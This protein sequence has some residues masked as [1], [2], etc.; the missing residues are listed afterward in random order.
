MNKETYLE[1]LRKSL[2]VL[3]QAERDDTVE[4]YREYFDDAGI[5]NETAVIEELGSPKE[6]AKKI[7][8]D[9][10]DKKF[11]SEGQDNVE[12]TDLH[13]E[14]Q[15][16]KKKKENS[17]L[18]TFLIAVAA[19]LALPL[20]PVLF[21]LFIA[22][23]A[24]IFSLIIVF[25]S[26]IATGIGMLIAGIAV[27]AVSFFMLPIGIGKVLLMTGAGLVTLGIGI[28]FVIGFAKLL[29]LFCNGVAALFAKIVKNKRRE[30]K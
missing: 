29:S 16:N 10:V 2:K 27:V 6:L 24:V 14:G 25:I 21:A 28:C 7:L 9:V 3:P 26:F 17:A 5:E 11:S 22:L 30:D 23:L 18:R 12:E 1:E 15:D 20:S 8:V 4:F 19:I 13:Q